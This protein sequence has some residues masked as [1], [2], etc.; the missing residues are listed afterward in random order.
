VEGKT[1]KAQIWDTA[2]QE[3]YRAITSA[4]YRGAVGALLVYDITKGESF[5]NLERWLKELRDHADDRIVV[6]VVGN[7]CDLRHLREVSEEEGKLFADKSGVATVETSAL[8]STNI[9]TAFQ[10]LLTGIYEGMKARQTEA[11]ADAEAQKPGE[12]TS[13]TLAPSSAPKK[14]KKRDCC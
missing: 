10:L 9:D 13:V 3:R 6:L 1:L 5:N 8:D 12:G 11:A 2:G 4:Y 7:K 14:N